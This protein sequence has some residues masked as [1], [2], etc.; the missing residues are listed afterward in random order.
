MLHPL[1]AK[2]VLSI[3]LGRH[4]SDDCLIWHSYSKG[5]FTVKSA[6]QLAMKISELDMPSSSSSSGPTADWSFVW[7]CSIPNKIKVFGWKACR[8]ALATLSNLA[9]RRVYVENYCPLCSDQ[10]EDL[11]HILLYCH[12][13]RQVWA[14]SLLPTQTIGAFT[15]DIEE[16]LA[17]REAIDLGIKEGWSNIILEGDC[18]SVINRLIGSTEDFST[19]GPVIAD[20]RFMMRQVSHC[21]VEYIPRQFNSFAH[22]L[23]RSATHNA[24]GRNHFPDFI[25]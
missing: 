14:L 8:N 20:I 19:I 10:K 17:A 12:F 6:Y 2:A 24:E 13:A 23:A 11:Q 16:S 15:G 18:Q 5:V 1:D 22:K 3:P 21:N 7:K 9:R 25:E 4:C